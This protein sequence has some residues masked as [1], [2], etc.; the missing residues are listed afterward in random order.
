M[1]EVRLLVML[2]VM[3]LKR[4]VRNE[5]RGKRLCHT[6]GIASDEPV[7]LYRFEIKRYK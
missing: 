2:L 5:G 1:M 7:K 3:H 4:Y 6:S